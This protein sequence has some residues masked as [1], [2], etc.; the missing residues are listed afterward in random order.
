MV[1]SG[2]LIARVLAMYFIAVTVL[3]AESTS[4]PLLE[5]IA[6]AMTRQMTTNAVEATCVRTIYERQTEEAYQ[7]DKD[8]NVLSITVSDI[9]LNSEGVREQIWE[10]ATS[11]EK[12]AH[13]AFQYADAGDRSQAFGRASRRLLVREGTDDRPNYMEILVCPTVRL[14]SN[15]FIAKSVSSGT[16]RFD[17]ARIISSKETTLG[18]HEAIVLEGEYADSDPE[19]AFSITVIPSLNCAIAAMTNY[20]SK[21]RVLSDMQARDFVAISDSLWIAQQTNLTAYIYDDRIG[22]TVRRVRLQVMDPRLVPVSASTFSLAVP[23]NARATE[24]TNLSESE[25][26]A[27]DMDAIMA[28]QNDDFL[29]ITALSEQEGHVEGAGARMVSAPGEGGEAASAGHGTQRAIGGSQ[30]RQL[31]LGCLMAVGVMIA[32][33]AATLA[34]VLRLKRTS[35]TSDR[36]NEEKGG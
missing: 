36:I 13:Y 18:E 22:T 17:G 2:V 23:P 27:R 14:A 28:E 1:R 26:L 5:R 35:G 9:V 31:F 6:S 29:A 24:V 8:A 11:G 32:A 34:V 21:G 20:D 33:G 25:Q 19:R 10:A 15:R 7:V 4:G 3:A 12:P 30:D 16:G